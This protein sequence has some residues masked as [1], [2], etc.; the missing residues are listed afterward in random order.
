M[1]KIEDKKNKASLKYKSDLKQMGETLKDFSSILTEYEF[2][3]NKRE[4]FREIHNE[5]D[6]KYWKKFNIDKLMIKNDR[7]KSNLRRFETQKS[8][9]RMSITSNGFNL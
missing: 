6:A 3:D 9:M 1:E 8:N 7:C 4:R 2:T 5:I